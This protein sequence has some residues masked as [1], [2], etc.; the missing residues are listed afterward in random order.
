MTEKFVILVVDDNANN[1]FTLRAVLAPLSD[2]EV[3]EV[4]SGEAALLLTLEHT[5]HLVLLD[6]Q[7]PGMDGFETA[8]HLQMTERTRNIPVVF[9]TAVF[10][11]GE[12]VARGYGL[13][14]VDYLTKPIDDNLLLSRVRLYRH[15]RERELILEQSVNQLL[16]SEKALRAAKED[17]EAANR[18]KSVFLA[19]MS[20]ELRTPLNAILGFAHLL[21]RDSR[22]EESSRTK[23]ATI[24]R[25]G[26]HLLALINDVLEIS[27]IEANRVVIL[28]EPFDLNEMLTGVE[29]IIRERTQA[30]GLAF[31][32]ERTT[33][34]PAYVKGDGHRL[35]QILINL[36]GNAAKYTNQGEVCLRTA[37]VDD[38]IDFEVSDT[39][40]GIAGKDLERIFQT[41]FQT[42]AGIA[43][44]EGTGLG[45][46]IS[47]E[48][49][50]L[51]GGQLSVRSALGRGSTFTLKAPLP[52]THALPVSMPWAA[53]IGVQPG[54]EGM[55]ILVVDDMADNRELVQQLLVDVGFDVRMASN[56]EEAVQ[57]FQSWQPCFI[58]MDMRM[59][60]LDG[61][62]ATR[63]IRALAGGSKVKI[64]ALTA[65]AFEEDRSAVLQAGCDD[66]V[67]KPLEEAA[68]FAVMGAL[69]GVRYRYAQAAP[70]RPAASLAPL[71]LSALPLELVQPLK[72]AAQALDLVET[73]EAVQ[74][75]RMTHP[76]LADGLS[77]LVVA[78]QFEQIVSLCQ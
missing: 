37:W 3:L 63:Q 49:A 60:V 78:F 77:A 13:G 76:A 48:Y 8:R 56:G 35:K 28:D 9:L 44:G 15:L 23:L 19:N 40:P 24:N 6:V 64:V 33:E 26:Q 32:V 25:A 31:T 66:M 55:R 51:M 10:K 57:F 12:F 18:A 67:S 58:W 17:A 68:I 21:Q 71:D 47:H 53:V 72:S 70:E 46:A 38:Q 65:S 2:C 74:A 59:P 1:R 42:E 34:L 22:M 11:S 62:Q 14:A 43:K 75:I 16:Q 27:R 4:D 29:E 5:I 7:M 45:L 61:Y 20:H 54:Y 30:K 39:G 52:Q 41:F 36:L 73:Q 69:L 50:R